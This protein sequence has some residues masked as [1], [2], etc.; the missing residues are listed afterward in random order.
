MAETPRLYRLILQ[1]SSMKRGVA[2]YS[3]L[4]GQRGR[5]IHGSRHYF[6]CGPVILALLDPTE[7]GAR[8]RPN[9]DYIYLSVKDIRKFHTRARKLRCLNRKDVHLE[10]AGDIVTRPWGERSFYAIDPFGNKFCFVEAGTEFTG[11]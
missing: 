11:R 9:S 1:V 4:L 6:D 2:F 10:S 7:E 8:A 5:S 3:R